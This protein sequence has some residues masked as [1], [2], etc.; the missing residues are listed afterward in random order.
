MGGKNSGN[1]SCPKFWEMPEHRI[2][3]YLFLSGNIKKQCEITTLHCTS[4]PISIITSVWDESLTL[5]NVQD[6][7]DTGLGWP[8]WNWRKMVINFPT[9]AHPG[10]SKCLADLFIQKAVQFPFSRHLQEVK[11]NADPKREWAL[12]VCSLFISSF[13]HA[14]VFLTV[15]IKAV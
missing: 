7:A 11:R 5:W 3:T 15:V 2:R 14:S 13:R 1:N 10:I 8:T 6:S 12:Q 9:A 4:G